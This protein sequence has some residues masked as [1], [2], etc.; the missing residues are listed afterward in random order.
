MQQR[1]N[2]VTKRSSE[3][4][5]AQRA[6]E[7]AKQCLDIELKS[8]RS[9]V[10]IFSAQLKQA[11]EEAAGLKRD[12][13]QAACEQA[14]QLEQARRRADAL[15]REI[16]TKQQM[17]VSRDEAI[18][19]KTADLDHVHSTADETRRSLQH[20]VRSLE[21]QMAA[22]KTQSSAEARRRQRAEQ[23]KEELTE[24]QETLKAGLRRL[25][26]TTTRLEDKNKALAR[27][28]RDIRHDP[29]QWDIDAVRVRMRLT[30]GHDAHKRRP[31][32]LSSGSSN[33][34]M[35]GKHTAPLYALDEHQEEDEEEDEDTFDVAGE[36]DEEEE[37]FTPGGT[38]EEAEVDDDELLLETPGDERQFRRKFVKLC[39]TVRT[40]YA[41]MHSLQDQN[42]ELQRLIDRQAPRLEHHAAELARTR[43][44]SEEL[45]RE[46]AES[47]AELEELRHTAT[48]LEDKNKDMRKKYARAL[49]ERDELSRNIAQSLHAGAVSPVGSKYMQFGSVH[50]LLLSHQQLVGAHREQSQELEGYRAQIESATATFKK[51]NATRQQME[52]QK[53]TL[54]VQLDAMTR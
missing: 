17:L 9:Q 10:C 49:H 47:Q 43:R 30:Q 13:I 3:L 5:C 20:Q 8:S 53:T 23:E 6:T 42:E 35:E 22:F 18:A 52:A 4:Q 15:Q 48:R 46:H 44:D 45:Q 29:A 14:V 31:R 11:Q 36:S 33:S 54:T 21:Q 2:D 34:Q 19:A 28:L 40:L 26:H 16:K 7:T 1:L 51:L 41:M 38:L 25:R 32:R 39:E 24:E 50:E 37:D 27:R 12:N